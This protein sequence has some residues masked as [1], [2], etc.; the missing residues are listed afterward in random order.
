MSH[1]G[2][3][4][5]SPSIE[6]ARQ[7]GSVFRTAIVYGVIYLCVREV[8]KVITTAIEKPPWLEFALAVLTLVVGPLLTAL[9]FK[10]KEK[11][12]VN[13]Q[14]KKLPPPSQWPPTGKTP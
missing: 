6:W 1:G 3:P 5:S 2:Q 11:V 7:F 14:K 9:G 4:D 13:R 12:S 8:A 10:L